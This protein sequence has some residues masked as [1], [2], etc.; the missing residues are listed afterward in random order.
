MTQKPWNKLAIA[1]TATLTLLL[2]SCGTNPYGQVDQ[3]GNPI[4]PYGSGYGYE[5]PYGGGSDYGS[6]YGGGS[7]YGSDY[8]SGGGSY[9]GG[10]GSDYGSGTGSYGSGMPVYTGGELSSKVLDKQQEGIIF[11]KKM[12]ATVQIKNPTTGILTGEITVHFTKKGKVVDTQTEFVSDLGPGQTH[13]F[14]KKS[15]KSADNV[16][17]S[18]VTKVPS[19]VGGTY[20]SGMGT[21]TGYGT[22]TGTGSGYD[23]GSGSSG[24][25]STGGGTYGGY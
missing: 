8:G 13:T 22:G 14:E 1:A 20:G 24:Y 17:V 4:D 5:D 15:R 18:V 3:Y 23:T 7:D 16:E 6:D 9:G 2:A 10:Y 19:N 12:V 11:F 21:G 25:P